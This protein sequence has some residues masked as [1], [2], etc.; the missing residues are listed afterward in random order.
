MKVKKKLIILINLSLFIMLLTI[1]EFIF[2]RIDYVC[3]TKYIVW[4]MYIAIINF[5]LLFGFLL[6]SENI[7]TLVKNRKQTYKP[8]WKNICICIFFFLFAFL[9][10]IG[11]ISLDFGS[12][13]SQYVSEYFLYFL[14]IG[15]YLPKTLFF[16][17][18]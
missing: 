12:N 9:K 18:Q 1:A 17:N 11:F 14:I 10:L 15:Y 7:I 4:P 2:N 8:S 13:I 6:S 5:G 3:E 16:D